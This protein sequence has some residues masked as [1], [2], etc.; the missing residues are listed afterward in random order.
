M[1][2]I[3]KTHIINFLLT[4]G[5]YFPHKPQAKTLHTW[6]KSNQYL[7]SIILVISFQYYGSLKLSEQEI[8]ERL[9]ACSRHRGRFSPPPCTPEHFWEVDFM[10]THEYMEKGFLRSQS[11]LPPEKRKLRSRKMKGKLLKDNKM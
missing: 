4:S 8:Q 2:K 6:L 3:T 7:W 11:E 5:K 9:Q 10:N 1:I